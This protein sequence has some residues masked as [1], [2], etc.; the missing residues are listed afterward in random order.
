MKVALV[1]HSYL[2]NFIG[3][4]ET[5]ANQLA[6]N[7]LKAGVNCEL[8][9]GDSIKKAYVHVFDKVKTHRFPMKTF[10]LGGIPYRFVHPILWKALDQYKPDVVHVLDYRHFTTDVS[11]FYCKL[12]SI[13]L[14]ISVHGLGYVSLPKIVSSTL[15]IYDHSLGSYILKHVDRILAYP[16]HDSLENVIRRQASDITFIDGAIDVKE[17]EVPEYSSDEV[18]EEFGV[19]QEHIILAVGRHSSQKGF[20]YLIDAFNR[21]FK[22]AFLL[23]VTTLRTPVKLSK[24]SKVTGALSYDWVKSCF[25]AASMF[26]QPSLFETCGRAM[27]EAMV[28]ENPIITT[29]TGVASKIIKHY[30]NG[31]LI[32]KQNVADIHKSVSFLLDNPSER[33]KIGQRARETVLKFDWHN[34]INEF[35]NVYNEVS[36]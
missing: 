13:P 26:V 36:Q 19:D 4:R 14:V 28:Y 34:V 35:I 21:G 6:K 23:L 7:T 25:N 1:T 9:V 16:Y 11:F 8:F 3:G 2:P 18:R 33:K 10:E 17:I 24:H 31:L 27:L 20:S 22:D 12:R 5:Y 29:K 32:R 30:C 15:K